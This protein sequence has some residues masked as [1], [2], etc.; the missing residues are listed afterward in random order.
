MPAPIQAGLAPPGLSMRC[1]P[2]ARDAHQASHH[3]LRP[4]SPTLSST[5]NNSEKISRDGPRGIRRI[6]NI[7]MS[8]C[9][10][11]I[12]RMFIVNTARRYACTSSQRMLAAGR[13]GRLA[14]DPGTPA[15]RNQGHR[16]GSLPLL[17]LLP[18]L[19]SFLPHPPPTCKRRCFPASPSSWGSGGTLWESLI[20]DGFPLPPYPTPVAPGT[21]STAFD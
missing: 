5:D 9:C 10:F 7:L 4:T 14:S 15:N 2:L 19:P 12:M 3:P 1:Q 18:L 16:F 13:R 11:K 6:Q 17:P 21:D 8:F 20:S